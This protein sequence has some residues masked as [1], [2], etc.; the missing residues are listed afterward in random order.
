M[1]PTFYFEMTFLHFSCFQNAIPIE[2]PFKIGCLAVVHVPNSFYQK[3]QLLR[4]IIYHRLNNHHRHLIIPENLYILM[5]QI[6]Q[7]WQKAIAKRFWQQHLVVTRQKSMRP[8]FFVFCS[9]L[10]KKL[11]GDVLTPSDPSLDPPGLC[12]RP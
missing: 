10:L 2:N 12:T 5:I 6:A 3:Q 4:I 1:T 11:S 7:P 8:I 9:Y